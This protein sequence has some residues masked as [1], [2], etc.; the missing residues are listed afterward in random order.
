MLDGEAEY[1]RNSTYAVM[2]TN[3]MATM[4][5]GKS[6]G[7]RFAGIDRGTVGPSLLVV[8]L[9]VLMSVVLPL[10]NRQTPYR[11]P[12]H[13]GDIAELAGGVTMVPT[14]GWDLATGALVGH[15][16]SVVG[17]TATTELVDGGVRFDVQ[18]APFAGTASALLRRV[19]KISAEANHAR[20]SGTAT[21]SYAVRTRQG[22]VGVGQD[23]FGVSRQGSVVAF[24][25]RLPGQKI[26]EGVEIVVSGPKGPIS[27]ARDDIVAMIRSIR[28]TS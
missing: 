4:R 1:P 8:A 5:L 12:V 23:F 13:R 19:R 10:I 7:D 22:A 26:G 11:H 21:H 18:A 14:A 27:R 17:T 9:A 28:T 24:V 6:R 2:R 3:R 15:T 16:R 20:G 25:L